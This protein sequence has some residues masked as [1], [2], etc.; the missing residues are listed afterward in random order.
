MQADPLNYR[1]RMVEVS[2]LVDASRV[3]LEPFEARGGKLLLVHGTSNFAV[4]FHNTTDCDERL[5]AQFGAA[6]FDGFVRNYVVPGFAHGAGS[7]E[8]TWD[9]LGTLDAWVDQGRVPADLVATDV[10]PAALGRT[11][12]MCR[13]PSWARYLGGDTRVAS[14]YICSS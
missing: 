10:S 14:N 1:Q 7:F 11:R 4:S 12:T 5:V 6:R 8:M 13:Y 2:D 3:T 9:S